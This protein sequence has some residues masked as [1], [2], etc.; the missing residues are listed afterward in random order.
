[1]SQDVVLFNDTIAKN[2]AYGRTDAKDAE[3]R[4]AARAADLTSF[5]DSL[6][7]GMQTVVGDRG[8]R[9][10]GGQR[11]RISI[12]RAIIKDA[13][14]LIL[15]EATSALDTQSESNV[16]NAVESLRKGRTTVVIAHRLSTVVNADRI[17]VLCDGQV[18]QSGTHRE[19]IAISG[20]YQQ[21][22][23]KMQDQE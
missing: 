12:A 10:S 14:V 4:E 9:V 17:I 8:V 5:I 13:P 6:P 23:A 7:Q 20:L 22:Y 21:L 3:V 2:I 19:L 11:Q 1:M 18:V 16:H 15:D